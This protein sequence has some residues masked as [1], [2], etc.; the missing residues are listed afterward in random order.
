MSP[1]FCL[2]PTIIKIT[3]SS[4]LFALHQL[5]NNNS[6][7]TPVLQTKTQDCQEDHIFLLDTFHSL[8]PRF[9]RWVS[10]AESRRWF[11]AR[12]V[13]YRIFWWFD[14][15]RPNFNW[16]KMGNCGPRWKFGSK[17]TIIIVGRSVANWI[18]FC[19]CSIFLA[20]LWNN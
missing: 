13:D 10:A 3:P 12:R 1:L 16:K 19:F 7:L 15:R 17:C 14:H 20:L 2:N 8:H 4:F 18:F 11:S 5:P 9:R 6:Y